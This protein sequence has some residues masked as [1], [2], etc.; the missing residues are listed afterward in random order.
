MFN[1][2]K[3]ERN[4]SYL[5]DSITLF[6]SYHF[7]HPASSF[8]VFPRSHSSSK[9]NR[10]F[11]IVAPKLCNKRHTNIRSSSFVSLSK[12]SLTTQLFFLLSIRK[13][14]KAPNLLL[15]HLIFYLYFLFIKNINQR[16]GRALV[17]KDDV[18]KPD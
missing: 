4:L 17:L 5:F 12:R 10:A 11:S 18:E 15:T 16:F 9:G 3:A 1:F 13:K 6:E 8:F 7:L 14:S 2:V